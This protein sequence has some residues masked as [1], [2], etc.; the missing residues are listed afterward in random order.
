MNC[1]GFFYYPNRHDYGSPRELKLAFEPVSFA[2]RD[3][4]CLTGWFFPAS[5]R[6]RGTVLHLHGNAGNMTG[7]FQHVAWLSMAGWNVLC[8]D[9]RGYGRSQGKITRAGSILD[10]HAALDYLLTRRDV[11]PS[12]IVVLG[13][14]LGAAIGVVLAAERPEV[15][16]LITDGGFD[17]YRR[18]AAWHI[19]RNP[20]LMC[21]AWWVPAVLMSDGLDP[22]EYI[23]RIAPR[24][25][26]IIHG[27]ADAV[28]PVDMARR[29]YAAAGEPK[30]LWL[31]DGADH[32]DPLRESAEEGRAKVLAFL[33]A[34]VAGRGGNS[35]GW[36]GL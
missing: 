30:V 5:G 23:H 31:V 27:T 8:F 15:C 21:V 1:D 20:L 12:G 3:G 24:P 11:D 22:I 19:R 6:A 14:S 25:V 13:Q 36:R 18:V 35:A 26:L 2:A 16:G 9:Y 28:V 33:E 10:A 32:Y 7:H 4:V 17:S 29:L 34:S